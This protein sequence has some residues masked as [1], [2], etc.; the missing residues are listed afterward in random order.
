MSLEETSIS[1]QATNAAARHPHFSV[2][3]FAHGATQQ[4]CPLG[5]LGG[6]G[7]C[8]ATERP[9]FTFY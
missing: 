4:V 1:T 7:S 3:G 5:D 8:H 2:S 6:G 9:N